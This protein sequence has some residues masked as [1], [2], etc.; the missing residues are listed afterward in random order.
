[1]ANPKS[2]STYLDE[3]TQG[4]HIS[5][6]QGFQD[7]SNVPKYKGDY[8]ILIVYCRLNFVLNKLGQ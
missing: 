8:Y 3:V 4:V 2:Q 5:D 7:R 6:Y 1:M